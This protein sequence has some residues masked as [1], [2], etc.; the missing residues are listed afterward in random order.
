MVP[1]SIPGLTIHETHL[2]TSH[3]GPDVL[4]T[5]APGLGRCLG[6]EVHHM[7]LVGPRNPAALGM[8]RLT[9]TEVPGWVS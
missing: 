8:A 5:W 9:A 7:E 1:I 4:R 2:Y 3:C 6:A